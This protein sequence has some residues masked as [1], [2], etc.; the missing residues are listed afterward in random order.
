MSDPYEKK[1]RLWYLPVGAAISSPSLLPSREKVARKGA[2]EGD[3]WSESS[4]AGGSRASPT[5]FRKVFL[6]TV[7]EGLAPP[8]V[9]GYDGPVWDRPLRNPD[10]P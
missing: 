9:L 3:F 7:G 1:G 4:M 10:L 6:R 5:Q 8:D 2:D